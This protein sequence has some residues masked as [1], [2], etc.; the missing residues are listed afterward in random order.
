MTLALGIPCTDGV[1]LGVDTQ[2]SQDGTKTPGQK[3][4]IFWECLPNYNVVSAS[5]GHADSVETARSEIVEALEKLKGKSPSPV[6]REIRQAIGAALGEVYA[7]HIDP[8]PTQ[9]ERNL[10]DFTLLVAIRVGRTARLFRTNR[11]QVLE[12]KRCCCLGAG[13]VVAEQILE[14]CLDAR[15]SAELAAQVAAY[16]VGRTKEH[17]EGVGLSTDV[18]V[19]QSNGRHWALTL[20]E[21]KALETGFAEFFKMLQGVIACVDSQSLPEAGIGPRLGFL[22]TAVEGLREAQKARQ[23]RAA[24]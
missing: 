12:E 7:R 14:L 21:V 19:I 15:P 8:L 18:H 3:I 11:A 10:M 24:R 22:R 2:I 9:E 16:V 17:V 20:P 13:K 6:V 5:S 4:Q 1:V 23:D